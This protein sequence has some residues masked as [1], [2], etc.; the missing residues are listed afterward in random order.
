MKNPFSLLAAGKLAALFAVV[1]LVL[2]LGQQHL[3]PGSAYAIAAL[4]GTTDVDAV[5]MAMAER[6]RA[7]PADA[8]LAVLAIAIA[9]VANTIV[10]AA[11][12]VWLGRG[13]ARLI[14]PSA[15]A[16]IAVGLVVLL[17]R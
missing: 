12:C 15:V 7:T 16:V 17:V 13:L 4:A 5:T 1:Q 10:K 8:E 11:L 3:P 6:V 14:V 2:K 9:C